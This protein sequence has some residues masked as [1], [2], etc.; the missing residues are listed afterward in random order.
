MNPQALRQRSLRPD[1]A[2]GEIDQDGRRF[3]AAG[4]LPIADPPSLTKSCD[5]RS[6][7]LP[8][9]MTMRRV[10]PRSAGATI[11]STE[12]LLPLNRSAV[13][14]RDTRS[15]VGSS[16]L[17]GRLTEFEPLF[18]EQDENALGG[19]G[20]RGKFKLR[21]APDDRDGRPALRIGVSTQ[22][23]ETSSAVPT[24]GLADAGLGGNAASPSRTTHLGTG[25]ILVGYVPPKPCWRCRAQRPGRRFNVLLCILKGFALAEP[26]CW[27]IK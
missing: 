13:A 16:H 26:L 4:I 3:A 23:E 8:A 15:P 9:P 25:R 27:P 1:S 12:P 5:L 10:T 6:R 2:A 7:T 24:C 20:Q 11:S 21:A 19:R 22:H 18:A 14:A 17:A